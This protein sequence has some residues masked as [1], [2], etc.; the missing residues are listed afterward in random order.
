MCVFPCFPEGGWQTWGQWKQ[1]GPG[2]RARIRTK[3]SQEQCPQKYQGNKSSLLG[4][5][6]IELK[7]C[8]KPYQTQLVKIRLNC[9][10][11]FCNL[12]NIC[13]NL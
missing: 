2:V 1:S 7:K 10:S 11:L 5:V 13:L 4:F 12:S 9:V 3:D 8:I 6:V